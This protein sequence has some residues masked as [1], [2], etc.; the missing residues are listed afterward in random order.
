MIDFDDKVGN[1][2]ILLIFGIYRKLN[3]KMEV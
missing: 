2:K 1:A 3:I